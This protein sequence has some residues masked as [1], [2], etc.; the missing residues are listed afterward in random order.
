MDDAGVC[1]GV[2]SNRR[3]RG[4]G[5]PA[6]AAGIVDKFERVGDGEKGQG[7]AGSSGCFKRDGSERCGVPGGDSNS[8]NAKEECGAQDGAKVPGVELGGRLASRKRGDE[9]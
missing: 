5:L 1:A 3:N 2:G 4:I 7:F 9:R 8:I 6:F